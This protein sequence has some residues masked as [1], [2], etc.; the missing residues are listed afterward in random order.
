ME[1]IHNPLSAYTGTI[2]TSSN[3][4]KLE[5][6]NSNISLIYLYSA[7]GIMN[8][9]DSTLYYL[10]PTTNSNNFYENTSADYIY[11]TDNSI[12]EFENV[13]FSYRVYLRGTSINLIKNSNFNLTNLFYIYQASQTEVINSYLGT[14]SNFFLYNTASLNF[15]APNN[16]MNNLRLYGGTP[17]ISGYVN[18]NN[19]NTW[20]SGVVLNRTL[21]FKV[22]N[23]SMNPISGANVEIYDGAT[24][25]D[26]GVTNALGKV[27]LNISADN[28]ANPNKQYEVRVN[29]QVAEN[30]S[31]LAST[32]PDG[33]ELTGSW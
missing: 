14:S 3:N 18:I 15:S 6:V 26:S 25:I 22:L 31:I 7:N 16:T 5:F 17:S 33:I 10:Y 19:F 13:N 2:A 1:N 27:N 29:G 32:N 20:Y 8:V 21:P 11:T 23:T 28:S 24:L 30:I 9:R 12:N 4:N